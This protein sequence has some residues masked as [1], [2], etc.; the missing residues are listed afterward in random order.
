M[1]RPFGEEWAI[2]VLRT[3]RYAP[4]SADHSDRCN[5]ADKNPIDEQLLPQ[6][7]LETEEAGGAAS[8]IVATFIAELVCRHSETEWA[9]NYIRECHCAGTQQLTFLLW[10]SRTCRGVRRK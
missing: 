2:C 9:L 6:R 3:A 5:E 8:G 1:R 10:H 4:V 7:T